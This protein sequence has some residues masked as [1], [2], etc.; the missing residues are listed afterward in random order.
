[1]N[2]ESNVHGMHEESEVVELQL[3]RIF[4]SI[5]NN[6]WKIIVSMLLCGIAALLISKFFVVPMYKTSA[7]FSIMNTVDGGI[8]SDI[9]SGELSTSKSL[10]N[11][12]IVAVTTRN[13]MEHVLE[14]T[15]LDLSANQLLNMVKAEALNK[16]QFLKITVTGN[17]PTVITAIA[18]SLEDV[19]PSYVST[20]VAGSS[21]K[22]VDCAVRPTNP[23]TPNHFKNS[24]LGLVVGLLLSVAIVILIE[25]SDITIMND[26]DIKYCCNYPVLAVVPN[27]AKSF[28]HGYYK[29]YHKYG[30]YSKRYGY[31]SKQNKDTASE[32]VSSIK[33]YVGK[34]IGFAASEAYKL[35]RTKLQYSFVD[36]RNCHV[37]AISSAL[38]GEGKSI[39]SVNTAYSFSQLN[40]RVL[41]IDCDMRRPTLARKLSLARYPGLSEYLTGL[42]EL[43]EL[44][45]TF[46]DE[47]VENQQTITVITAGNTPPN[48]IE[49]L[50]SSKMLELITTLREQFDYI[51]LDM[52]PINDVSDALVAPKLADGVLLVVHQNYSSRTAIRNAIQQFEFVDA[53]ILGIIFNCVSD[54]IGGYRQKRYGNR[55]SNYYANQNSYNSEETSSNNKI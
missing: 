28:G 30:Y 51:I 24:A 35:L 47:S 37:I 16:T 13:T 41:L 38:A 2:T 46:C 12:Y 49:L 43:D 14:K 8:A 48:P 18:H 52:P 23:Y 11:S 25:I 3:R 15:D 27:M 32:D 21:A 29:R 50:S 31:Y 4:N 55:Y 33:S 7:T 34:N 9:S 10:V 53:K 22:L 1:M 44:K 36:D 54:R 39:S 6:L 19:I 20:I 5:L 45:Q 26:D 42:V 40:K 17:D